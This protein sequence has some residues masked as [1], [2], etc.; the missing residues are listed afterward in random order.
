MTQLKVG[1]DSFG[2]YPRSPRPDFMVSCIA[3][4]AGQRTPIADSSTLFCFSSTLFISSKV[5]I[6]NRYERNRVTWVI[7]VK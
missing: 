6:L 2:A 5:F 3:S 7:Q 4:F 1:R